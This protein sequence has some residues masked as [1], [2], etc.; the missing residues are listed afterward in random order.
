MLA[1][2]VRTMYEY[3]RW[4]Y[5]RLLE[6]VAE[7]TPEQLN[8]P[9]TAGHGS[10]RETLVH[11]LN[12]QR[13]WLSWWDGSNPAFATTSTTAGGAGLK[14]EDLPDAG[15]LRREWQA[16]EGRTHTFASGLDDDKLVLAYTRTR[17][18]QPAQSLLLWQMMLHVV[19][20]GT[21]H[22]SEIA[23]MLTAFDRSPGALDM[24][25]FLRERGQNSD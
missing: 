11:A 5:G 3:N 16:I 22:R 20:H 7:L 1:D 2:V 18:G 10:I 24:T 4:A 14:V 23:A 13:G 15:S 9:G 25:A 19:N 21:Q 8:A 12:A 6:R 17:P